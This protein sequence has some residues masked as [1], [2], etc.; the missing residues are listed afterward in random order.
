LAIVGSATLAITL[1]RRSDGRIDGF[2]IEGDVAELARFLKPD[3]DSSTAADVVA[4]L[5][6]PTGAT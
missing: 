5:V 3:T 1:A 6:K 2:V 4:Y